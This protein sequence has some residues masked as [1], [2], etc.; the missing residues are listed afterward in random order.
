MKTVLRASHAL[1]ALT[2]LV[3]V[4]IALAAPAFAKS[5]QMRI[6]VDSRFAAQIATINDP[7]GK[8]AMVVTRDGI[9]LDL[10]GWA[11]R[12]TEDDASKMVGIGIYAKGIDNLTI[13]GG[14]ISGYK[15]GIFLEDCTNV[16]IEGMVIESSR[17]QKL[18]STEERYDES[19]WLNQWSVEEFEQYGGAVYLKNCKNS[20]IIGVT[21]ENQQNGV[22]LTNC[23]KITVADCKLSDNNGWGIHLWNS[24]NCRIH[25]NVAERCRRLEFKSYSAGGDSAGILVGDDSCFNIIEDNSFAYGGDSFFLCGQRPWLRPSNFNIVRRN[26]C[27]FSP[28]NGIEATFSRGN[29][30]IANDVSGSRYGFWAGYSFES[31]FEGNVIENCIE[32]GIAIEHGHA[33]TIKGNAISNCKAGIRVWMRPMP[34]WIGNDPSYDYTI[35]GNAITGAAQGVV[36]ED[37]DNL[38][39]TGNA[40]KGCKTAAF[41]NRLTNANASGNAISGG[42]VGFDVRGAS[43]SGEAGGVEL[44]GNAIEGCATPEAWESPAAGEEG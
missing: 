30:F 29:R 36:I 8:G 19:D 1:T 27:R 15:W 22:T 21:A 10:D 18:R 37:T 16:T 11:L 13:S 2:C 34:D 6:D 3:C 44:S 43:A 28:H 7:W 41:L 25:G 39:L 4:L 35:T 42:E 9:T 20:A 33:N 24:D 17:T 40:F 12:S 23:Q 5:G 32:D 14:V 38:T 31:L 26:D